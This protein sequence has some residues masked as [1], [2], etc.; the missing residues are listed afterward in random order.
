MRGSTRALTVVG[1]LLMTAGAVVL[2]FVVYQL[3]WTNVAAAQARSSAISDLRSSWA[4]PTAPDYG[5]PVPSASA[6]AAPSASPTPSPAV[7]PP[8][9]TPLALIRIPRLGKDW[10]Q[11]IVEGVDAEQLHEGI[12]HY[13][14]TAL[15]GGRGNLALA[16]HRATNGEPFRNLDRMR[17]G[18]TVVVITRDTTYTYVVDKPWFLVQPTA[19]EVIAPVPG[20]PGAHAT[21]RKMTLTT[22]NP[23]WAST[24]RLIVDLTLRS[25]VKRG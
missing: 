15:P 9:G 19:V 8:K 25:A 20:K 13:V 22:C 4:S 18:D 3:W 16:G 5:V 12:G 2:L 11:P 1:D 23:R 7:R 21:E 17:P 14:G 24:Q 6:S 10:A